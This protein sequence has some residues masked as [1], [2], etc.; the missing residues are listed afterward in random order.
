[1]TNKNYDH[2][3]PVIAKLMG[4]FNDGTLAIQKEFPELKDNDL[5][6]VLYEASL[7]VVGQ[8]IGS[9]FVANPQMNQPDVYRQAAKS[10][11]IHTQKFQEWS[12]LLQRSRQLQRVCPVNISWLRWGLRSHSNSHQ[13][14]LITL[15]RVKLAVRPL[16]NSPLIA[17]RWKKL[18]LILK[19]RIGWRSNGWV[20]VNTR[21]RR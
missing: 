13:T 2:L 6:V 3:K 16:N 8:V 21:R 10:L 4:H 18:G 11:Q 1:M 5:Y 12:L 9:A 14:E 17:R 7:A 15:I 19:P 20:S